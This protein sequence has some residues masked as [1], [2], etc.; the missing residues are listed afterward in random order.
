M[1]HLN[2]TSPTVLMLGV[3]AGL[4]YGLVN[5]KP[6]DVMFVGAVVAAGRTWRD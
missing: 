5:D 1:V 4:L 6:A 3:L 2:F